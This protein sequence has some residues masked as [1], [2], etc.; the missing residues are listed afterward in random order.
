MIGVNAIYFGPQ[1]EGEPFV[2]PFKRL[3][4]TMSNISM[5][6]GDGYMDAAFF[7]FFGGDNGACTPNQHINI[8]T[9]ALKQTHAPTFESFFGNLTKFWEDN[10]DYQGRLLMQRYPN[11]GPSMVPDDATAFPY[12]DVK[13]FM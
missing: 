2:E 11:D 10:P 9:I 1:K 7:R 13:T 3:G 5:V 8:Y 6:P 12:R 4:P